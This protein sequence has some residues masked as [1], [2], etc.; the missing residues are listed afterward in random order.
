MPA[1]SK[2]A[3][4]VFRFFFPHQKRVF[5]LGTQC[6]PHLGED[7]DESSPRHQLSQPARATGLAV[8]FAFHTQSTVQE[9]K[10]S[11]NTYIVYPGLFLVHKPYLVYIHTCTYQTAHGISMLVFGVPTGDLVGAEIAGDWTV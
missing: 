10:E 1:K 9:K 5:A 3:G 6:S 4:G 11:Q 7:T 2:N 8:K